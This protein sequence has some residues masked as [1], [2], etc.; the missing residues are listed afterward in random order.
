MYEYLSYMSHFILRRSGSGRKRRLR[1]IY[2]SN[3]GSPWWSW[4]SSIKPFNGHHLEFGVR[5]RR[6]SV[7]V[8]NLQG[9]F[10][11]FWKMHTLQR[12]SKDRNYISSLYLCNSLN[13]CHLSFIVIM[14]IFH[15]RN[16]K[17]FFFVFCFPLNRPIKDNSAKYIIK[18]KNLAQF[19]VF[20]GFYSSS[21]CLWPL[22]WV[23]F[24]CML[25]GIANRPNHLLITI[26]ILETDSLVNPTQTAKG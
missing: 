12:K 23:N 11:S 8:D 15:Q 4:D 25:P 26:Q 2:T 21:F 6:R 24:K 9:P 1:E 14:L 17:T 3:R 10:T 7:R 18:I 19:S 16:F 22:T 13:L 5:W 20:L